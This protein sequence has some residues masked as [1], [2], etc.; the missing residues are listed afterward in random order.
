MGIVSLKQ[1]RARNQRGD[2]FALA[3]IWI[4][5]IGVAVWSF[6]ILSLVVATSMTSP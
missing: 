1:C 5:G 2:G 4:G 6:F 3:A